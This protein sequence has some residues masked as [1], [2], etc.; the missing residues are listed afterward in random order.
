[1]CREL[2]FERMDDLFDE[3]LQKEIAIG[4][5]KRALN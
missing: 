3:F 2:V 1:M 4:L 5:I